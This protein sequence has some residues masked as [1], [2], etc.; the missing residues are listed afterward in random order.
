MCADLGSII[1]WLID[2]KPLLTLKVEPLYVDPLLKVGVVEGI[3]DE[4]VKVPK[5]FA[6]G[7]DGDWPQAGCPGCWNPFTVKELFA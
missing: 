4:L 6:S 3:G 2:E 7:G 1:G 5:S